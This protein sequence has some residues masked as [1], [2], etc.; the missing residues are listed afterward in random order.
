MKDS[1]IIRTEPLP[2][3]DDLEKQFRDGINVAFGY[4]FLIGLCVGGFIL[5]LLKAMRVI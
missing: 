2:T 4:G 1:W 5:C 3:A